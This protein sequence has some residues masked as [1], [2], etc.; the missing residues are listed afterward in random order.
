MVSSQ[1]FPSSERVKAILE[2]FYKKYH[3]P[4][5]IHPDPLIFP[6]RYS[7]PEDVEASAFIA[8]SFALGRV[9]AIISFLERVLAA[10]GEPAAGLTGRSEPELRALFRDFKYRFF[11]EDDIIRFIFGLRRLYLEYG[12]IENCFNSAAGGEGSLDAG[13][14]QIAAA[15]N[16]GH[17]TG[18]PGCRDGDR[19]VVSSPEQGSACKRLNLFLRWVVRKDEIDPG[20]WKLGTEKL[21]IPLDTHVMRVSSFL[22]LTSRRTADFKTAVEITEGLKLFD[23]EDPVR[24][25][26]SMSRIGI[27]PGLSYAELEKEISVQEFRSFK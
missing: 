16:A 22:G 4:E 24:Y 12:S 15:V 10:L 13:L 18:G 21:V 23:K 2:G 17:E 6:R 14:R 11:S 26:F 8:A 5:Y 1:N 27:H 25:D 19:N 3:K 7:R 9:T 20:G